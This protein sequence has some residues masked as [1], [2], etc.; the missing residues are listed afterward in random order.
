MWARAGS[1]MPLLNKQPI[2]YDIP[3]ASH[4]FRPD[5]QV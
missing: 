4:S 5:E 3:D 2:E 1:T